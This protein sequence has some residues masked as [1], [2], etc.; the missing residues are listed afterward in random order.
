[1]LSFTGMLTCGYHHAKPFNQGYALQIQWD[2]AIE[3]PVPSMA[4]TGTLRS[5]QTPTSR[6]MSVKDPL[7]T[8]NKSGTFVE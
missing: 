6:L 2:A 4:R 7:R 1:M 3:I 8:L 5:G